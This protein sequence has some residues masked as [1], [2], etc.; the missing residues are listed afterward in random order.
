M[1]KSHQ[2]RY[3]VSQV[4]P[5]CKTESFCYSFSRKK[6][7]ISIGKIDLFAYSIF[8]KIEIL[9]DQGVVQIRPN[10]VWSIPS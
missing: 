5:D 2:I 10:S 4:N 1:L 3:G 9:S 7:H 6:V 8:Q